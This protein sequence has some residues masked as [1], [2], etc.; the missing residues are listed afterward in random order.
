[1]QH[2]I[3]HLAHHGM[4]GFALANGSMSSHQSGEG[5]IRRALI[6]AGLVDWMIAVPAQLFYSTQIP[7]CVWFLAKSKAACVI[8]SSDNLKPVRSLERETPFVDAR[9]RFSLN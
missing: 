5:H 8:K 7:V 6:E 2:F 9:S 3:H 4:G 1:M